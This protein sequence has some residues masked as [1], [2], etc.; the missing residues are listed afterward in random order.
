MM[1]FELPEDFDPVQYVGKQG[2]TLLH[3]LRG[4]AQAIRMSSSGRYPLGDGA[5]NIINYYLIFG[6]MEPH[7]PDDSSRENLQQLVGCMSEI[8]DLTIDEQ[9]LSEAVKTRDELSTLLDSMIEYFS[10]LE[11]SLKSANN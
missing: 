7:M 9:R 1:K 3:T 4:Y 2:N 11:R 5:V 6:N 8:I 10:A